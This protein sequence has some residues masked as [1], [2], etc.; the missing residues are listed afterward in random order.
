MK[1]MNE[2]VRRFTAAAAAATAL[3]TSGCAVIPVQGTYYPA[4]YPTYPRVVTTPVY[5]GGFVVTTPVVITPGGYYS[6]RNHHHRNYPRYVP[7]RAPHHGHHP[8]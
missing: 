1:N 6:N 3:A 2:I 4:A 5:T 8:R 7:H